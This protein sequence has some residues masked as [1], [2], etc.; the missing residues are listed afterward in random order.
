MQEGKKGKKCV[1]WEGEES[2]IKIEERKGG[3]DKERERGEL[4]R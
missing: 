3:I 2:K 1:C 4:K